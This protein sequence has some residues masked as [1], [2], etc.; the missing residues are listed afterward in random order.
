LLGETID[1][2][3]AEAQPLSAEQAVAPMALCLRRRGEYSVLPPDL[4]TIAPKQLG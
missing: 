2:V 3:I 1:P 4:L